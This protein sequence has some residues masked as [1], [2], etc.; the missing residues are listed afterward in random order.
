MF[1]NEAEDETLAKFRWKLQSKI[2]KYVCLKNSIQLM[3]KHTQGF[4]LE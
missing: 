3:V 4:M 2:G 1:F